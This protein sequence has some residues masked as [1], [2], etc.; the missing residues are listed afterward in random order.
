MNTSSRTSRQL[1]LLPL[2]AA[3]SLAISDARAQQADAP[4]Q[5]D[6]I[7]I[8][9][10]RASL[11]TAIND[12]RAASGV[13]DSITAEDI[14]KFPDLNLSES[15]QRVTGVT[16]SRGTDGEGRRVSVRGA[17]SEF[18]QTTLNGMLVASGNAGR[19]FNFDTFASE[20]F[21]NVSLFKTPT[22]DMQEGGLAAT[23]DLRT[24][25]PLDIRDGMVAVASVQGH[26]A[27]QGLNKVSP[28]ASGMLGGRFMDG[29]L[30]ALVSVAKSSTAARGDIAQGF[31]FN[32][33]YGAGYRPAAGSSLEVNGRTVTDVAE[34]NQIAR[35]TYIPTLPRVGPEILERDRLG[36]TGTLQFQATDDLRIT[37]NTLHASYDIANL[38]PTYDGMPGYGNARAPRSLTVEN[39]YAL[40]GLFDNVPQ[41]SETVAEDINAKINHTTLDAKWDV[42]ENWTFSGQIGHSNAREDEIRRTY[43][44]QL[45]DSYQYDMRNAHYPQFGPVNKDYTNVAEYSPGQLRFRP[46]QRRDQINSA[47]FDAQHHF[48]DG[49][50]T[51]IQ[52]GVHYRDQRKTRSRGEARRAFTTPFSELAVPLPVSRFLKDAPAGTPT[53]YPIV[54]IKRGR[55]L[56]LPDNTAYPTD[57]PGVFSVSE[58]VMAG[59][60]RSDWDFDLGERR[61]QADL[62]VRVARTQQT[63]DGYSIAGGV[64]EAVSIKQSYTDVL[65]N[66][67]ARLELTPELMARFSL[68]KAMTRA[69]LT[70]LSPGATVSATTLSATAGNPNLAPFRA[71]Q[72]DLALEWYF[73]DEA[74]LSATVFYKNIDSFIARVTEQEVLT[75]TN[76]INDAGEN[77]SGQ[78]FNVTRPANGKGGKLHGVEL[79]WQQPFT[80]L[81]DP[82]DGFGMLVNAT[83]SDSRGSITQGGVESTERLPGQS[84]LSYNFV[85]YYEKFG[86][87]LRAAYTYRSNY[88]EAFEGRNIAGDLM[89]RRQDS[90]GQLD[91]SARYSVNDHLSFSVDALN[92][93]GANSYSYRDTKDMNRSFIS[94]GPVYLAGVRVSF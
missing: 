56:L 67:N 18:T 26:Y 23:V 85:T 36:V 29:R 8:T 20:L 38:R 86:L 48:T 3:L 68:N 10:V 32:T 70:D 17:P 91:L 61:L 19:D 31:G 75:G 47:R 2:C 28:R 25:S 79:A 42:G 83:W 39:G 33:L 73:A 54:D 5:L 21:S 12:K 34:L 90:R 13:V 84:K 59:F 45:V 15:L 65:P 89:I 50:L 4:A 80:F 60:V 24:P 46:E 11:A 30:G 52:A 44:Y 53:N 37:L 66:L 57:F 22:A 78:V 43:L 1:V 77:V 82:F 81:P 41:R 40:V 87:S 27:S 35:S 16:I 63:S 94:Q 14:G 93:N 72:A 9:G 51:S 76:L 92:V 58:Q 88:I 55:E 71:T 74:L 7:Q 69:T 62:G 6:G 49:A 64:P